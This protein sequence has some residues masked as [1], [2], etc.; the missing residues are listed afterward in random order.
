M[1]P[2]SN[3]D[4]N[5][6]VIDDNKNSIN[7]ENYNNDH[8]QNSDEETNSTTSGMLKAG[9]KTLI[10]NI[11]LQGVKDNS[12]SPRASPEVDRQKL[13]PS[14]TDEGHLSPKV[15]K[16]TVKRKMKALFGDS[17]ESDSEATNKK[18]KPETSPKKSHSHERDKKSHS[19]EKD[20]KSHAH[21]RDKTHKHK[22]D[23]D[24]SHSSSREKE[25]I[26]SS[27][28][29][30]KSP[31]SSQHLG[32]PKRSDDLFGN[33]SGE[34]SES[35]LVIDEVDDYSNNNKQK[36]KKDRKETRNKDSKVE[37]KEESK[38]PVPLLNEAEFKDI[39][40]AYK[41]AEEADRVLKALKQFSEQ[42]PDPP[43]V[44][45]VTEKPSDE[46]KPELAN[47]KRK[48]SLTTNFDTIKSDNELNT[49]VIKP[50]SVTK[51]KSEDDPQ[52]PKETVT[53]LAIKLKERY[54]EKREKDKLKLKS[55]K[56]D[57]HKHSSKEK[58]QKTE[59]VDVASLVV[60]L[61]MPYYKKERI[62]SRE[63]FKI[64]ARH[65]VHQ[66]LAIQITGAFV[67][68]FFLALFRLFTMF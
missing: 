27:K 59:K 48:L 29:H 17:S 40:K 37:S 49:E 38:T 46:P 62:S 5:D 44:P 15:L 4:S 61:L 56:K 21:D 50:A 68:F 6:L 16:P 10:I 32:K 3:S 64:T 58:P 13:T 60:K 67:S 54:A 25:K 1:S 36:S 33:L 2:N 39:D 65:I 63:L 52:K 41:L 57:Q 47:Q 53:S 22:K 12:P 8:T 23:R 30:S 28:S 24:K 31:G 51:R 34:E 19:H 45:V 55:E 9:N 20:E 26:S 7:T 42:P 18:A 11:T 35:E 14:L 66:L 43:P